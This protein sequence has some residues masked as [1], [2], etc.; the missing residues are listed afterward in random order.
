VPDYDGWRAEFGLGAAFRLDAK[1]Q[2][3]LD[4]EYSRAPRYERPWSLNLGCRT[5]W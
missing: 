4:Y 3:Y 5:L 2:L 1:S